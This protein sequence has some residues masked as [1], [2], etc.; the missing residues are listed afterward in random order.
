MYINSYAL[1]SNSTVIF[2]FG[3]YF[4]TFLLHILLYI[5]YLHLFILYLYSEQ[6]R[7]F[8]YRTLWFIIDYSSNNI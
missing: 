2:L 7:N 5:V 4:V 1:L 3:A 8:D 6:S